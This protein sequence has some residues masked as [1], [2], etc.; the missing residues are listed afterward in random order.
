M[1]LS[2]RRD[3]AALSDNL[4]KVEYLTEALRQRDAEGSTVVSTLRLTFGLSPAEA[5]VIARLARSLGNAV[6]YDLIIEAMGSKEKT[7]D[8]KR[9]LSVFLCNARKKMARSKI[10]IA[11]VHGY[12]LCM[13]DPNDCLGSILSAS[14]FKAP[15]ALGAGSQYKQRRTSAY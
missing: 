2:W 13:N 14:K 6:P 8:P 5:R 7:E 9:C 1:T 10:E 15:T 11:T 12:G 3:I 4:S